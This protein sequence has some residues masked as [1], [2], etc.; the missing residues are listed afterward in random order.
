[1]PQ[2]CAPKKMHGFSS[3]NS[4]EAESEKST[5]FDARFLTSDMSRFTFL[6][7]SRTAASLAMIWPTD[8]ADF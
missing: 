5:T 2:L 6:R 1:M 8:S 4:N 3:Q 7:L